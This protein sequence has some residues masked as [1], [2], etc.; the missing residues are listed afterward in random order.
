MFFTDFLKALEEFWRS[1]V[2][3][4]FTLH[5]LNNDGSD[6]SLFFLA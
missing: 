4:T 6:I 3:P 5:R 1:M 2:I